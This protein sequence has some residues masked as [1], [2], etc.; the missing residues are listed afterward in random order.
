MI[1]SYDNTFHTIF[2]KLQYKMFSKEC[3]SCSIEQH[4]LILKPSSYQITFY[5]KTSFIQLSLCELCINPNNFTLLRGYDYLITHRPLCTMSSTEFYE[6]F[7]KLKKNKK[8]YYVMY[9]HVDDEEDVSSDD[10][11]DEYV[12]SDE[13]NP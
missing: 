3:N 1:Y 8:H 2:C 4:R 9:T 12:S 7:I 10:E 13:Y 6:L 5:T 11:D